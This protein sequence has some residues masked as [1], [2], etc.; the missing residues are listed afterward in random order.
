MSRNGFLECEREYNRREEAVEMARSEEGGEMTPTAKL[1]W[2]MR[3]VD[4]LN[5]FGLLPADK[6]E[7]HVRILQQWWAGGFNE[8]TG[9]FGEWRDVPLEDE[10]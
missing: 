3:W 4:R 5:G 10:T 8:T 9:T 1:R 6:D 7:A 2:V